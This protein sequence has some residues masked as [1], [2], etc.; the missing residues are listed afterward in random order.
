MTPL[1]IQL[2]ILTLAAILLAGSGFV[3]ITIPNRPPESSNQ[4]EARRYRQ[5][6]LIFAGMYGLAI[7]LVMASTM[8]P[9]I[10]FLAAVCF[11]FF[12]TLNTI[13]TIKYT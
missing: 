1:L 13:I 6:T 8:N 3:W 4:K 9:L 11:I 12:M 7:S 10:S 5:R 2:F